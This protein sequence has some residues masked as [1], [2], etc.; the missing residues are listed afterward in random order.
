[1]LGE[2]GGPVEAAALAVSSLKSL[3]NLVEGELRDA[4]TKLQAGPARRTVERV[5]AELAGG[6]PGRVDFCRQVPT[7]PTIACS[8]SFSACIRYVFDVLT[9]MYRDCAQSGR[10][11][12]MLLLDGMRDAGSCASCHRSLAEP[13]G[14][15]RIYICPG[16]EH[17]ICRR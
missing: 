2:A 17:A 13:E 1:M 9:T 12:A 7:P 6:R 11:E 8:L 5:L 10:A 14:E 16:G 15:D 4:L 3:E